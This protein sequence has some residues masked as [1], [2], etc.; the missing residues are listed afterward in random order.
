MI[1]VKDAIPIIKELCKDEPEP[2]SLCWIHLGCTDSEMDYCYKCAVK[3]ENWLKYGGKQPKFEKYE[4]FPL[5]CNIDPDENYIE[6]SISLYET[7]RR[8]YCEHCSC[9]L[10]I[11]LTES[12]IEDEIG[13]FEHH[14]IHTPRQWMQF[15][16]VCEAVEFVEFPYTVDV[17]KQYKGFHQRV[18]NILKDNLKGL[19]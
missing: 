9:L 13:H 3:V 10:A 19:K 8:R 2:E 18:I 7:D 1:T 11:S 17:T 15:L 12:L 5:F 4:V 16:D 14:G 6:I